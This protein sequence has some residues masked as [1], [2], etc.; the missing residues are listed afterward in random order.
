MSPKSLPL[1]LSHPSLGANSH[2]FKKNARDKPTLKQAET[3]QI[4]MSLAKHLM[5]HLHDCGNQEQHKVNQR[6]ILAV[7]RNKRAWTSAWGESW[8][9][10]GPAG[11]TNE[12]LEIMWFI[13]RNSDFTS[14]DSGKIFS[15]NF[16]YRDLKKSFNKELLALNQVNR[17]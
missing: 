13:E 6:S 17:T 15:I 5:Q 4:S 7:V 8:L 2:S 3:G 14:L 10:G 1:Q 16:L 11:R 12:I 9:Q